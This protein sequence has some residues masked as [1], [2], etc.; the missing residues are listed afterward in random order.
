[1]IDFQ[2]TPQELDALLEPIPLGQFGVCRMPKPI[3]IKRGKEI[4][5]LR[6]II[7]RLR[8]QNKG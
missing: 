2:L 8:K 3:N 6:K 7:R 5:R 4:K 1:M